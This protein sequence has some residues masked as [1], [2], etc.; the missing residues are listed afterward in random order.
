MFTMSYAYNQNMD[1][2]DASSTVDTHNMFDRATSVNQNLHALAGI[3]CP[4]NG[5]YKEIKYKPNLPVLSTPLIWPFPFFPSLPVPQSVRA[6]FIAHRWV[7]S[8]E[9][10]A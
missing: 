7:A 9:E 10:V 2:W 5:S 1:A 6:C 3:D 8:E 4:I